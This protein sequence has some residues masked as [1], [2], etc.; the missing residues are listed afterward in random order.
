MAWYN[1]GMANA[2]ENIEEIDFPAPVRMGRPVRA[3]TPKDW[4]TVDK[5]CQLMCTAEEIAGFLDVSVD[6]LYRRIKET[7]DLTFAEYLTQKRVGAQIALRR[8][9]WQ[10]AMN[11]NVAMQIFLGKQ[12]LGQSNKMDVTATAKEV[13]IREVWKEIGVL[14]ERFS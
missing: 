12:Y 2:L 13:D 8:A 10:S 9:Q 4:E 7:H 3:F 14:E 11:G 1:V 5:L 6:T